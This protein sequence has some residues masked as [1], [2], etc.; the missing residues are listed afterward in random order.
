MEQEEEEKEKEK[1][2]EQDE[3]GQREA[4]SVHSASPNGER[5]SCKHLASPASEKRTLSCRTSAT[6]APSATRTSSTV[7]RSSKLAGK[8]GARLARV[9]PPPPPVKQQHQ[10]Q[11]AC[12]PPQQ[13]QQPLAS[14][15][16]KLQLEQQEALLA[17]RKELLLATR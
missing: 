15:P 17:R 16:S 8:L 13:Q 10:L 14:L 11:R 3:D 5:P 1:E 4:R 7:G 6:S 9:Q 12:S 2:K